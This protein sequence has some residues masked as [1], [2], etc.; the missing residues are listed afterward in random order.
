MKIYM[1]SKRMIEFGRIVK[2]IES[3]NDS[4]IEISIS[5]GVPVFQDRA[6]WLAAIC[7][8]Y[9][10]EGD[11]NVVLSNPQSIKMGSSINSPVVVNDISIKMHSSLYTVF[12]YSEENISLIVDKYKKWIMWLFRVECG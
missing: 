11:R 6:T 5:K 4:N 10:N 8:Y 12:K 1:K 9:K 7:E 2:R 3:S